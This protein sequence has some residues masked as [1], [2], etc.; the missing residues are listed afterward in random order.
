MR[1]CISHR[2]F[3]IAL[4][5]TRLVLADFMHL[6]AA[7]AAAHEAPAPMPMMAGERCAE[8]AGTPMAQAGRPAHANDGTCCKSSQCPCLHAPALMVTLQMPAMFSIRCADGSCT[9]IHRISDPPAV[10]FRPP[11]QSPS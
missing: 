10:F 5:F 3:V 1:R 4:V 11:I 9:R 6:P 8:M 7:Q 2:I